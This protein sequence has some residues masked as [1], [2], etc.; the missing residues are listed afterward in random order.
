MPEAAGGRG[1][2]P[3]LAELL[4]PLDEPNRRLLDNVHPADWVNPEPAERYHLV[5]IGAGTAGLVTAAGA[6]GLGA[7]VALVEKRLMGG[8][9]LNHGC[10]PSKAVIRAA[11]AWHD[12]RTAGRFGGPAVLGEGDF[13]AAMRRMREL[14]AGISA[15]D[16]AERF[17]GLGVDVF[18]GEARLVASDAAEVDG[19]Q[20]RFRRAVIATGTRAL[21]P[22]IPGIGTCGYLTNE[23]VFNLT[24]LPASLGVLGAGP[25]GVELAQ[26]FARF[27]SRV[28]LFDIA[29]RILIREDPE[30]AAVVQRAL[31]EDGV[32]LELGC[33]VERVETDADGI[34]LHLEAHG[35]RP[36]RRVDRLLL[37]VGRAPNVEALGLEAAGVD[38]G[39][40]G[41][42]VDDR[43]RTS[44]PR[45]Y[46]V[47]D[48]ASKLQFTH[49]ADALARVAIQ[50]ALF[51][52]RRKASD[53]L[54]PWCTYSSPELAHVGLSESEARQHGREVETVTVRMSE[55]DRAVVDG[56]DRGFLRLVIESG[57]DRILGATLVA[58][59]AGDLVGELAL[60]IRHGIGLAKIADT[61]HPYPTRAEVIK[62]AGDRWNRGR[63]TP[64]VRRALDL[65]FRV[66][67]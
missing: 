33:A 54:V 66:L 28:T 6:A 21:Q 37:A 60:A 63:L 62:K 27:G 38:Y 67:G 16:S 61:I 29:D 26:A 8:D 23:T 34:V 3:E 58:E 50:N 47:G 41:I 17:R 14:R 53:L 44:N 42:T 25:I 55:V 10:V 2:D 4:S 30:A 24:E 52:G 1:A 45:I 56:D 7:R 51:F 18:L 35:A 31:V 48:V 9:C 15:H 20:L 32:E 40:H 64:T 5:V 57:R 22:P 11:R 13:A 39:R 43:L 59:H 12:A 49:M 46:A 65:F 19:R 36:T